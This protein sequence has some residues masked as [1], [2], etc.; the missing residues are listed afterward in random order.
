MHNI[1][2]KLLVSVWALA[3]MLLGFSGSN[4]HADEVRP[5][6]LEIVDVSTRKILITR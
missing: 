6:Y 2:T 5:A 3:A 4:L 1:R